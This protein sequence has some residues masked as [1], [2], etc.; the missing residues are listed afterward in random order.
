MASIPTFVSFKQA[1]AATTTVDCTFAPADGF[2][3]TATL[4]SGA[5]VTLADGTTVAIGNQTL[6]TYVPLA[7]KSVAFGAGTLI[8]L[9]AQ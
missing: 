1:E 7:C 9:R 6:G 5:T 3:V 8:F 4:S 2:L